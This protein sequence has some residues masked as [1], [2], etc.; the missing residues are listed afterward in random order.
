M[1]RDDA[2]QLHI[3]VDGAPSTWILKPDSANLPGGV[4]NEAFC[5]LLAQ[6][7]GLE[8]PEVHTGRAYAGIC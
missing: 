1:H 2:G 5:L 8:V 6:R 3:P 7:I 4:W